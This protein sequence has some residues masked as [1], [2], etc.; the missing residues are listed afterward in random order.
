[1]GR[2]KKHIKKMKKKINNQGVVPHQLNE[3]VYVT[4]EPKKGK[5]CPQKK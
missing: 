5:K 3:E 2:N 1:M 4:E